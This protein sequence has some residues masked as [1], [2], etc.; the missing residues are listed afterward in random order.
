MDEKLIRRMRWLISAASVSIG[1][2]IIVAE[3]VLYCH[4]IGWRLEG[5]PQPPSGIIPWIGLTV[6]GPP[7]ELP[8]ISEGD[9]LLLALVSLPFFW[10]ARSLVRPDGKSGSSTQRP[11]SY[12]P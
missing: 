11:L 2:A 3:A 9:F 6:W 10:I 1:L 4:R 8:G 7:F 12:F 5:R